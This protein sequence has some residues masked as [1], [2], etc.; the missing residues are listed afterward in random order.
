M[1]S[2]YKGVIFFLSLIFATGC[3]KKPDVK[4]AHGADRNL[5]KKSELLGGPY[6]RRH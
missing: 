6:D 1:S 5:F 2:N 3:A 4:V